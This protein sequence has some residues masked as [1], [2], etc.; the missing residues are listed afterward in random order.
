MIAFLPQRL[1]FVLLCF[2]HLVFAVLVFGLL[3]LCDNCWPPHPRWRFPEVSACCAVG[4]NAFH[5]SID[6]FR[7]PSLDSCGFQLPVYMSRSQLRAI[8][9]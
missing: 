7:G 4:G 9:P 5:V 2:R 3:T 6:A 8:D 1:S